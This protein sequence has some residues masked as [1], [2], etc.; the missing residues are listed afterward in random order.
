MQAA[1]SRVPEK[2]KATG[3]S[4]EAFPVRGL[5]HPDP[6]RSHLH[7]SQVAVGT[8]EHLGHNSKFL[9]LTWTSFA[10]G[11]KLGD[12]LG[13]GV[14]LESL[15]SPPHCGLLRARPVLGG[16]EHVGPVLG[17]QESNMSG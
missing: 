6:V 17:G 16:D 13:H 1:K 14:W 5:N 7:I 12:L 15:S 3:A 10:A 4:Q 8:P 11:R 9:S 2:A